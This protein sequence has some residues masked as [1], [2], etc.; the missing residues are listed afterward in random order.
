MIP[1][2]YGLI[3]LRDPIRPGFFPGLAALLISLLLINMPDKNSRISLRWLISV[4]LAFLG[5]GMCSV[6]QKMQQVAFDGAY[7]NEFMIVSLA[8]VMAVMLAVTLIRERK[9]LKAITRAGWYLPLI[10]GGLNGA[11]NLWVMILSALMPVSVMF[12]S[13][14]AGSLVL[15]YIFSRLLYKERLTKLQFIGFV[16]GLVSVILLN[17]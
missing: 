16:L 6:T 11:V 5:N 9:H 10:C 14:S 3:F 13:I 4:A 7:K 1:S 8:I 15:T 12:P 2:I 17:L